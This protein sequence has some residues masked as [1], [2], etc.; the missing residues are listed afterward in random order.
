MVTG[1]DLSESEVWTGELTFSSV[2][3]SG[4]AIIMARINGRQA[5]HHKKVVPKEL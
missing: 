3:I 2:E 1:G 5:H 4:Y